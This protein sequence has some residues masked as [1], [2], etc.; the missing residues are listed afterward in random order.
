[1][2]YIVTELLPSPSC[3]KRIIVAESE[4]DVTQNVEVGEWK[5]KFTHKR[6]L[7]QNMREQR[8]RKV[9]QAGRSSIIAKNIS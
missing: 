4:R 3:T 6:Q 7:I 5:E 9:K 8:Y 2:I 1:M